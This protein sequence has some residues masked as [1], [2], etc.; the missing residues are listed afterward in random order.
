MRYLPNRRDMRPYLGK[1]AR[2]GGALCEVLVTG[3]FR[4]EASGPLLAVS[5]RQSWVATVYSDVIY[6]TVD[7]VE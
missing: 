5:A 6:R 7:P 3:D 1:F 2:I 4:P